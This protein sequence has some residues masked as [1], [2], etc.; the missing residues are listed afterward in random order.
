MTS[1][2]SRLRLINPIT[3]GG[4]TSL[5]AA[6]LFGVSSAVD[7]LTYY[8][9][10]TGNPAVSFADYQHMDGTYWLRWYDLLL[11]G[12]VG[13]SLAASRGR[14][15]WI[16]SPDHPNSDFG[17]SDGQDFRAGFSS[18]PGVI[19]YLDTLLFRYLNSFIRGSNEFNTLYQAPWL[20]PHPNDATYPFWLYGE[21][22]CAAGTP[23]SPHTAL[24]AH[25]EG[26]ARWT[27]NP[28][29][30][31]VMHGP[32][33]F[34]RDGSD[35][36]SFQRV[37]YSGS[38]TTWYAFGLTNYSGGT[39]HGY[40]GYGFWI[41]T[42][43]GLTFIQQTEAIHDVAGNSEFF[44][45]GTDLINI[46]GQ[47]Y[48]LCREDEYNQPPYGAQLFAQ[49]AKAL[50]TVRIGQYVTLVAVDSN[51]N[52][53]TSPAKIRI[54]SRYAGS[55]PGPTYLQNVAGAVEDGILHAFATHGMFNL[56]GG[57]GAQNGMAYIGDDDTDPYNGSGTHGPLQQQHLDRYTYIVDASAAA[58]AAPV[59]V[60]VSCAAGVVT[61]AWDDALPNNTYR[62]YR[63]T[64][65]GTQATLV[66]DVTGTS[67]TDSPTAS[68]QYWYKVVTLQSGTERGNRVVNTYVS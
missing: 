17:C 11:F 31:W 20:T 38:G 37:W 7:P 2:F 13:A 63:G 41:S 34:N 1:V 3:H 68:S 28:A 27:G 26:L 12:S 9:P 30:A 60:T 21:G 62:V 44:F 58:A 66:G 36:S 29:D 40:G 45:A 24:T 64:S 4:G 46:G 47:D 19:P 65:A 42:D 25:E 55:Y 32:S 49:G 61:L 56:E 43:D 59:G 22:G 54:S 35:W 14:Y 52:A 39:G 5:R 50:G 6:N 67:T 18:D 16:A 48:A 51:F 57:A 23:V 33:H 10:G 53:L 15:L 8:T